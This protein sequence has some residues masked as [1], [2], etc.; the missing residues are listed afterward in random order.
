[1]RAGFRQPAADTIGIRTLHSCGV[2]EVV[3]GD[4]ARQS[5][6]GPPSPSCSER[7]IGCKLKQKLK[8]PKDSAAVADEFVGSV[9]YMEEAPPA[10]AVNNVIPFGTR[11][12]R[13]KKGG[14]NSIPPLRAEPVFRH[15]FRY[16]RSGT[17]NTYDLTVGSLVRSI[18][19]ANTSTQFR[20]IFRTARIVK[21]AVRGS[22]G[23]IGNDAEVGLRFV[24]ANTNEARIIDSTAK[25]DENAVVE[26]APPRMSL[27]GFWQDFES[28]EIDSKLA[29][30]TYFG[31]GELYVDLTIEAVMDV[32][33]YGTYSLGGGS[34]LIAGGIYLGNLDT[35]LDPVGGTSI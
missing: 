7:G 25:V 22:S 11:V 17:G 33:R 12:A 29:I 14:S 3:K 20:P 31:T 18:V 2:Q 6:R 4:S 30:I 27:A 26:R 21:V 10:F 24:G 13:K 34:G 8:N 15:T 16:K 32:A 28:S 9:E 19:A 1:M 5:G 23:A 35:G